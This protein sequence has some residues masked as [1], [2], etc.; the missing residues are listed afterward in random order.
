MALLAAA[1][2]QTADDVYKGREIKLAV[3]FTTGGG[4]EMCGGE[5]SHSAERSRRPPRSVPTPPKAAPSARP[6]IR[7]SSFRRG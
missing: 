4:A 1:R 2:A 3:G 6:A 5:P 7:P